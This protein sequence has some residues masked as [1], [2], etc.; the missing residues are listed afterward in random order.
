MASVNSIED[1][2]E[3]QKMVGFEMYFLIGIKFSV[4]VVQRS[5][6]F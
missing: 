2:A 1:E 4:V 3:L 6:G 5:K